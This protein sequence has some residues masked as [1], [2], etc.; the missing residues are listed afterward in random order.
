MALLSLFALFTLFSVGRADCDKPT[1][2]HYNALDDAKVVHECGDVPIQQQFQASDG[3]TVTTSETTYTATDG[4]GESGFVRTWT[5][6]KGACTSGFDKVQT[7]IVQDT[8]APEIQAHSL[9]SV[10]ER[11]CDDIPDCQKESVSA[12]DACPSDTPVDVDFTETVT[13]ENPTT[14]GAD[15][16]FQTITRSWVFTDSA[17]NTA[18][19]DQTIKVTDNNAPEILFLDNLPSGTDTTVECVGDATTEAPAAIA[20]DRCD[21]VSVSVTSTTTDDLSASPCI[22]SRTVYTYKAVDMCGNEAIP[23]TRTVTVVDTT[24]PSLGHVASNIAANCEAIPEPC[25]PE[26]SDL[27]DASDSPVAVTYSTEIIDQPCDNSYTQEITFTATDHCGLTDTKKQTLT[28]TDTTP[29][30]LSKV[31]ATYNAYCL[32]FPQY[33]VQGTDNCDGCVNILQAS[34][35]DYTADVGN[36]Y[37]K[38]VTFTWSAADSCGNLATDRTQVVTFDDS[39]PPVSPAPEDPHEVECDDQWNTLN[40]LADPEFTDDCCDD[41][42]VNSVVPQWDN[43]VFGC[44]EKLTVTY[45][46][47]DCAGNQNTDYSRTFIVKDNYGP[48]WDSEPAPSHSQMG[49][50]SNGIYE[51]ERECGQEL[52]YF[53]TLYGDVNNYDVSVSDSCDNSATVSVELEGPQS[54]GCDYLYNAVL[55]VV[56]DCGNAGETRTISFRVTDSYIPMAPA[57][58]P[59][60]ECGFTSEQVEAYFKAN[61]PTS[62]GCKDLTYTYQSVQDSSLS[63]CDSSYELTVSYVCRVGETPRSESTVVTFLNRNADGDRP[64][65]TFENGVWSATCGPFTVA[66]EETK[67]YLCPT[68]NGCGYLSDVVDTA[69]NE[70]GDTATHTYETVG[71]PD[72]TPPQV[73]STHP[74]TLEVTCDG[75]VPACPSTKFTDA[76]F[77]SLFPSLATCDGEI[78]VFASDPPA[79]IDGDANDCRTQYEC[80]YTI[81][82]CAGNTGTATTTLILVDTATPTFQ[83]DPH[84]DW[85]HH[86]TEV[87]CVSQAGL[88]SGTCNAPNFSCATNTD[89][90]LLKADDECAGQVDVTCVEPKVTTASPVDQ[91]GSPPQLFFDYTATDNCGNTV[92][93]KHPVRIVDRTPPTLSLSTQDPVNFCDGWAAAPT[94]TAS[95]CCTDPTVNGGLVSESI[96]LGAE[97]DRHKIRTYTYTADDGSTQ[98]V[99]KTTTHRLDYTPISYDDAEF[100]IGKHNEAEF[101]CEIP[102]ACVTYRACGVEECIDPIITGPSEEGPSGNLD[103]FELSYVLVRTGTGGDTQI[104]LTD[105]SGSSITQ[106]CSPETPDQTYT[107]IYRYPIYGVEVAESAKQ[108]TISKCD[109]KDAIQKL[110]EA[111]ESG[112]L[113]VFIDGSSFWTNQLDVAQLFPN[114]PDIS[115]CSEIPSGQC[116]CS[117]ATTYSVTG[118]ACSGTLQATFTLTDGLKGEDYVASTTLS[119]SD[120]TPPTLLDDIGFNNIASLDEVTVSMFDDDCDC[121]TFVCSE[122]IVDSCSGSDTT[123]S[124][125]VTDACGNSK[126][127]DTTFSC[128]ACLYTLV[129]NNVEEE[130]S[131][132]DTE[133]TDNDYRPSCYFKGDR[134]GKTLAE[135]QAMENLYC[136]DNLYVETVSDTCPPSV[137]TD[138]QGVHCKKSRVWKLPC[139]PIDA[140]DVSSQC[141][142]QSLVIPDNCDAELPQTV[143]FKDATPPEIVF[144]DRDQTTCLPEMDYNA[145]EDNCA[146]SGSFCEN[147][148]TCKKISESFPDC[149]ASN[150]H[151][152]SRIYECEGG[153][154][155]AG[156]A[157]AITTREVTT[158]NT[159]APTIT[160]NIGPT[161]CLASPILYA[162]WVDNTPTCTVIVDDDLDCAEDSVSVVST[163]HACPY[164]KKDVYTFTA[165]DKHC[166]DASETHTNE[167]LFGPA[168][169]VQGVPASSNPTPNVDIVTDAK[170]AFGADDSDDNDCANL[171]V[172][173]VANLEDFKT[174]IVTNHAS[175]TVTYIQ[176]V[177]GADV[178]VASFTASNALSVT[179][180]LDP[181]PCGL[182]PLT[183]GDENF[184]KCYKFTYAYAD[185]DCETSTTEDYYACEC[186]HTPVPPQ[187]IDCTEDNSCTEQGLEGRFTSWAGA[188]NVNIQD[189]ID[190]HICEGMKGYIVA[191]SQATVNCL[192]D[193]SGTELTKTITYKMC[194][195]DEDCIEESFTVTV[196]DKK[197]PTLEFP[198]AASN[199]GTGTQNDP[200]RYLVHSD[201]CDHDTIQPDFC[202]CQGVDFSMTESSTTYEDGKE[203]YTILYEAKERNP[204]LPSGCLEPTYVEVEHCKYC[205]GKLDFLTAPSDFGDVVKTCEESYAPGTLEWTDNRGCGYTQ[206]VDPVETQASFGVCDETYTHS[207]GYEVQG[208]CSQDTR[209]ETM[210]VTHAITFTD[211]TCPEIPDQE[212]SVANLDLYPVTG[213][214]CGVPETADTSDESLDTHG[215]GVPSFMGSHKVIYST[216]CRSCTS[217]Y[218]VKDTQAP[219]FH[220]ASC[221]RDLSYCEAQALQGAIFN[222]ILP[223]TAQDSCCGTT[224][225]TTQDGAHDRCNGGEYTRFYTAEDCNGNKAFTEV[226]FSVSARTSAETFV[227]YNGLEQSLGDYTLK[228]DEATGYYYERGGCTQ[229][230]MTGINTPSLEA[231]EC[232]TKLDRSTTAAS[233]DNCP[234][235]H[236]VDSSIEYTFGSGDCAE[237]VIISFC[238][239]KA[240][241]P[242]ITCPAKH[243]QTCEDDV[244]VALADGTYSPS[245]TANWA[246][247]T[248]L[249]GPVS[250]GCDTEVHVS[251]E[252]T[253]TQDNCVTSSLQRVYTFSID[254][255]TTGTTCTQDISVETVPPTFTVTELPEC[256]F[257]EASCTGTPTATVT[258]C[259]VTVDANAEVLIET[260]RSC[261]DNVLYSQPDQVRFS[262]PTC[263]SLT[264]DAFPTHTDCQTNWKLYQNG[265]EVYQIDVNQDCN[266]NDLTEFNW[267]SGCNAIGD[268]TV[269]PSDVGFTD[270]GVCGGYDYITHESDPDCDCYSTYPLMAPIMVTRNSEEFEKKFADGTALD[271]KPTLS[272]AA[273]FDAFLGRNLE[274]YGDCSGKLASTG[275]TSFDLICNDNGAS[276]T[277]TWDPVGFNYDLYCLPSH[278]ASTTIDVAPPTLTAGSSS[279]SCVSYDDLE[280]VPFTGPIEAVAPCG[281]TPLTAVGQSGALTLEEVTGSRTSETVGCVTTYSRTLRACVTEFTG[282]AVSDPYAA[283]PN[284]YVP[285]SCA[286]HLTKCTEVTQ[287]LIVTNTG[288]YT[289][290]ALDGSSNLPTDREDECCLGDIPNLLAVNSCGEP[291]QTIEGTTS[292]PR[293]HSSD[294]TKAIYTVTYSIAGNDCHNGDDYSFEI[295]VNRKRPTIVAPTSKSANCEMPAVSIPEIGHECSDVCADEDYSVCLTY[296]STTTDGTCAPERVRTTVY[297]V[298]DAYGVVETATVKDYLKDQGAPIITDVYP[299]DNTVS[300]INSWRGDHRYENYAHLPSGCELYSGNGFSDGKYLGSLSGLNADEIDTEMRLKCTVPA[301]KCTTLEVTDGQYTAYNCGLGGGTPT[302]NKTPQS[303]TNVIVADIEATRFETG[304]L[305]GDRC[306][307]PHTW[308]PIVED[309]YEPSDPSDWDSRT[310]QTMNGD[311]YEITV[312]DPC[313]LESEPFLVVVER[314]DETPPA[315]GFAPSDQLNMPQG[316]CPPDGEDFIA[317]IES[318]ASDNCCGTLH[319]SYTQ[320]FEQYCAP[321]QGST[322]ECYGDWHKWITYTLTD[323][324]GNTATHTVYYSSEP[325]DITSVTILPGSGPQADIEMESPAWSYL[326]RPDS[327]DNSDINN[328]VEAVFGDNP[329]VFLDFRGLPI[330]STV[331]TDASGMDTNCPHTGIQTITWTATDDCGN[332]ESVSATLRLNDDTPPLL[333][334]LPSNRDL[335]CD[336]FESEEKLKCDVHVVGED[337]AVGVTVALVNGVYHVTYVA[338]D[339]AG[340]TATHVQQITLVD[341]SAPVFTRQPSDLEVPCDCGSLPEPEIGAVDN[342]DDDVVVTLS[343]YRMDKASD[344]STALTKVSAI[345]TS[346]E[347]LPVQFVRVWTAVDDAGNDAEHRQTITISDDRAP[348]IVFDGDIPE[349]NSAV[350][351]GT[352]ECDEL[353]ALVK[354]ITEDPLLVD[355]CDASPTATTSYVTTSTGCGAQSS[356]TAVVEA[357]DVSGNTNKVQFTITVV[358]NDA[359]ALSDPIAAGTFSVSCNNGL[360]DIDSGTASLAAFI[361]DNDLY[362]DNG[363]ST[364]SG[365]DALV[366]DLFDSKHNKVTFSVKDVCGHKSET[367]IAKFVCQ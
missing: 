7:I 69:T 202:D 184:P 5:V 212:C 2:Y 155:N 280:S 320:K 131:C 186:Y 275:L 271:A 313:G 71:T 61:V 265:Q 269:D 112:D 125:T 329:P 245:D 9:A 109:N 126:T 221:P 28:V 179:G 232:G 260:P 360:V 137:C 210:S 142:R 68:E 248:A 96:C 306:E 92:A 65:P 177:G 327:A 13:P 23:K 18:Q 303:G 199:G 166:N 29:P 209:L 308:H 272:C 48:T 223:V 236:D 363:C 171:H 97:N 318:T 169:F 8:K 213:E 283:D 114:D 309:C 135:I 314:F 229:G 42:T 335:E 187:T 266:G 175:M 354:D 194:T 185:T 141:G 101:W 361:T 325:S 149:T 251:S 39:T 59:R 110:V 83:G 224:V 205:D 315:F 231:Y 352:V 33:D 102:N 322:D 151:T 244:L 156:N 274:I 73:V 296:L 19:H 108:R 120:D 45:T 288:D 67:T 51:I 63:L 88:D 35:V 366:I 107:G 64:V 267:V 21:T 331:T 345:D 255:K 161:Q 147:T 168:D 230:G 234:E 333:D 344:G 94:P 86:T 359:P 225:S 38:T 127:F 105:D 41:V 20:I 193:G 206:S 15:K 270:L 286:E 113:D 99:T 297:T 341:K 249:F 60:Q 24:P 207:Y 34:K 307:D 148:H 256:D 365:A 319:V 317:Q 289:L 287:E 253:G 40:N 167:A 144:T 338:T 247:F 295:T 79:I 140:S 220:I 158:T 163:P 192:S 82:D 74:N 239:A 330:E 233:S 58:D 22:V 62:D 282:F 228:G 89:G 122:S 91:D 77:G 276:I 215:P 37:K 254:F 337:I 240:D 324:A 310:S 10:E 197:K 117:Y 356:T 190:D 350:D 81:D 12:H 312:T 292:G 264:E 55:S 252:T 285:P 47:T 84:N 208:E 367:Y 157:V 211:L 241:E 316:V 76:N 332:S 191:I 259:G 304:C 90:S 52:D 189:L 204:V 143:K 27:C 250:L 154:D 262:H 174:D 243:V 181:H 16:V 150:Q 298:K 203:C 353:D 153:V 343:I 14:C 218:T 173:L 346:A 349:H 116:S 263:Q 268:I 226:S 85:N 347:V 25:P 178:Q 57:L 258:H 121:I 182:K 311:E 3:A 4:S 340:N 54:E 164:R 242:E 188:S 32:D 339:C 31:P 195:D 118:S 119:W 342:C 95:D 364:F 78:E 279:A 145:L 128:N 66:S 328:Q 123:I 36:E 30:V 355:N 103:T 11:E 323:A 138:E 273:D 257:C 222:H 326:D 160:P 235:G 44:E 299:A 217:Y 301:S 133:L 98:P 132:G 139:Q 176:H 216:Q 278:F 104:T 17:G 294:E 172:A 159:I 70:C 130:Y 170:N 53:T 162:Q 238:A 111:A 134:T 302:S 351:L 93:T 106:G 214:R 180:P 115:S 152:I 305:S 336:E 334:H 129:G 80:S 6:T 43:T 237:T 227:D 219:T 261:G 246:K 358:D 284:G 46:A 293:E 183:P 348:D 72:T 277:G 1:L 201:E 281:G 124:C 26:A 136:S 75:T 321:L 300:R 165:V 87:E 196:Q 200:Y 362:L 290:K 50:E 198:G 146:V 100:V 357:T 291:S 56:D 49:T